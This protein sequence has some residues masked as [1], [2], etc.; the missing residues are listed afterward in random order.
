[1]RRRRARERHAVLGRHRAHLLGR[2][3]RHEEG[4]EPAARPPGPAREQAPAARLAR[5]DTR[6]GA[7][8]RRAPARAGRC[9]RSTPLAITTS[10]RRSGPPREQVAGHEHGAAARGLAAQQAA[11][12]A[13]ARR[14]EAVRRLVE[15]ETRVAEQRGGNRQ[16]LAHAHR[17]AL[18][19][20][21][22]G[23]VE[24]D[25]GE[26][27]LHAPSRMLS[28]RGKHA[29]MVAAAAAGMEARVLEH[30]ADVALGCVSSS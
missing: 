21:V 13:D 10:R 14:V 9:P 17:V 19:A 15:D 11:H 7:P 25:R 24:T 22:R 16:A 3:P 26:H 18:H 8:A 29:Q 12:P 28:G 2:A 30:R 6:D 27:L 4:T 1:M 23:G 20:A 5:P